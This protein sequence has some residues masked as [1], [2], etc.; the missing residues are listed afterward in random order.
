VFTRRSI[1]LTDALLVA[2]PSSSSIC[3]SQLII[4][5]YCTNNVYRFPYPRSNPLVL[6][7]EVDCCRIISQQRMELLQRVPPT[8]EAINRIGT[9]A[10]YVSLVYC[11]YA[12]CLSTVLSSTVN[13]FASNN[14][15]CFDT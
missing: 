2:S 8:T 10:K 11:V 7:Q 12:Q 5:D 15:Q 4:L 1:T 9:T 13:V 6:V 3:V 14:L